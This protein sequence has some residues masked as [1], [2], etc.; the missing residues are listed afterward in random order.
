MNIETVQLILTLSTFITVLAVCILTMMI[1]DEDAKEQVPLRTVKE[2]PKWDV[3]KE[4][5]SGLELLLE[6]M[7]GM[8]E[9]ELD[10]VELHTY[11]GTRPSLLLGI[12][13]SINN[14]SSKE[15][16]IGIVQIFTI[17][18]VLFS[19][20]FVFGASNGSVPTTGLGVISAC[21]YPYL[22]IN[23][24]TM[25]RG[26]AVQYESQVAMRNLMSFYLDAP[27]FDIA[28][29]NTI[30]VIK[31][32]T[33]ISRKLI[34]YYNAV[35][36]EGVGK[37]VAMVELKNELKD[38]YYFNMF[39]LTAIKAENSKAEY[40][41]ALLS[42]PRRY[43]NLVYENKNMTFNMTCI[44]VIYVI[45]LVMMLA[46]FKFAAGF[47]PEVYSILVA[48]PFGNLIQIVAF[49]IYAGAGMFILPKMQLVKVK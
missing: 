37:S 25:H 26:A 19:V 23:L 43:E 4:E 7:L 36:N 49:L 46:M 2:K 11:E 31:K 13:S 18:L 15:S 41:K 35:F 29:K 30:D 27:N 17:S 45:G 22:I 38:D 47:D 10:T 14:L 24:V 40:K 44:F 42:I 1:I 21:I 9:A 6:S 20:I 39:M 34:N 3:P 5:S 16:R 33:P 28:V 48:T 12:K 32:G 8:S